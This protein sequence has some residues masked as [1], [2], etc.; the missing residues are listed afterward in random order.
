MRWATIKKGTLLALAAEQ[1]D[2][3]VTVDRNLTVQ[4]VVSFSIAVIV[5]RAKTNRLADLAPLVPS[6]R[7]A[8]LDTAEH[9]KRSLAEPRDHEASGRGELGKLGIR[10]CYSASTPDSATIV[11][12]V[13]S[14]ALM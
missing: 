14:C 13:S 11:R 10:V 12:H 5:L 4:Q 2:V 1:F 7:A 3:F 6:L 8:A 9:G